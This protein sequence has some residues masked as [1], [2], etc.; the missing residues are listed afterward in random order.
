ML[1]P[2]YVAVNTPEGQDAIQRDL[3]RFQKWTQ[4]NLVRLNKT[5]YNIMHMG[6]GNSYYQ[7]KLRNERVQP[8]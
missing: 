7:Y 3:D 5:K 4:V 6:H 2:S 8:C 1:S